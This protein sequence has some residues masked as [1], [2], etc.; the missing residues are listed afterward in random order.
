MTLSTHVHSKKCPAD[1]KS[2]SM[3]VLSEFLQQKME[4]AGYNPNSLARELG[5]DP[6]LIHKVMKGKRDPSPRILERLVEFFGLDEEEVENLALV[7]KYGYER[8]EKVVKQAKAT[9]K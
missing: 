9:R 5:E 1:V 4:A 2:C 3:G 6:P 7:D 8:L